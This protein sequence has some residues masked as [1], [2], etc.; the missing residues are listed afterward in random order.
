MTASSLRIL[1]FLSTGLLLVAGASGCGVDVS[2]VFA[3]SDNNNSTAGSGPGGSGGNGGSGGAGGDGAG[4]SSTTTGEGA[5]TTGSTTSSTT[6]STTSSSTT[7]SSTTTTTTTMVPQVVACGGGD[8]C[9]V[10]A[11]ICCWDRWGFGTGN[12]SSGEC[13]DAPVSPFDCNTEVENGG[14][15]TVISCQNEDQC[16]SGE[17]CCGDVVQFQSGGQNLNYYPTVDCRDS[18]EWPTRIMCKTPNS[19]AECPQVNI[20]GNQVQTICKASTLL[21]M[22]YLVCGTP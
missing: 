20:Q 10:P 6:G 21:P 16:G 3:S 4:T 13:Y 18:C 8:T 12:P 15:Q 1:G 11:D 22:G 17:S 2:Q 19:T 5:G 7:T 9:D 14:V